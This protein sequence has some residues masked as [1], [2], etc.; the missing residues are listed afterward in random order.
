MALVQDMAQ[1]GQ[2]VGGTAELPAGEGKAEIPVGTILAMIEQAQKVLNNVH[3]RMHSAQSQEFR[4]LMRCFKENPKAFW[5]RNKKPAG[6]MGRAEL[7]RRAR[8]GRPDAAGRPEHRR[9]TAS[10]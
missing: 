6:Q 8:S 7:P 9:A 1:T 5:Q 2:R 4:L 3:K 10:A